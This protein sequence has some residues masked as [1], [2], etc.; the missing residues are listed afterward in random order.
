MLKRILKGLAGV[1]P[2][3][4]SPFCLQNFGIKTMSIRSFA[5][6]NSIKLD[7]I[8]PRKRSRMCIQFLQRIDVHACIAKGKTA[9]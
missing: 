9:F 8:L 6:A 3:L 2:S 4:I 5:L 7:A 1:C